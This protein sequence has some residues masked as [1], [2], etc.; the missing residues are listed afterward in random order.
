[1]R[2]QGWGALKLLCS[3]TCIK[4]TKSYP[5]AEVKKFTHNEGPVPDGR[6]GDGA[7]PMRGGHRI[8]T[9]VRDLGV[10][11]LVGEKK[12][13]VKLPFLTSAEQSVKTGGTF[14]KSLRRCVVGLLCSQST[15]HNLRREK[16]EEKKRKTS[17]PRP[18]TGNS[19]A[20]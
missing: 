10:K 18:E 2:T 9:G 8:L 20:S 1:V 12:K 14:G 3:Q 11:V 4:V 15:Q 6:C 16:S 17:F 19:Y 13:K 5:L 7:I